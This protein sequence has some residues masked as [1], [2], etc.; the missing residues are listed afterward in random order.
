[1]VVHVLDQVHQQEIATPTTAQL[2]A[3]GVNGDFA[4]KSVDLENKPDPNKLQL[5]LVEK[6]VLVQ[7]NKIVT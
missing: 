7:V 4:P 3:N 1:M 5:N 6:N 2:I